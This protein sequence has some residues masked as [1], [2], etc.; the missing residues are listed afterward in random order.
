MSSPVAW[1]TTF[2]AE[3]NFA[4]AVDLEDFRFHDFAFIDHVVTF[5]TAGPPSRRCAR[6]H[7]FGMK[8]TECAEIDDANRLFT[9]VDLADLRHGDDAFDPFLRRRGSFAGGRK[10]LIVP[11]SPI[12]ILVPVVSVISRIT[13][14]PL[15]ITSRILSTGIFMVVIRGAFADISLGRSGLSPSRRGYA[16]GRL[17]AC[18]NATFMI[19]SVMP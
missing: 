2:H 16:D 1:S 7:R 18:V 6:G 12:S 13:L 17:F 3:A 4:A 15:P 14:P 19:S 10:M 5:D 11:S 8:F 9:F